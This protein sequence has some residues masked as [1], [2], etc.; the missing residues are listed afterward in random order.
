METIATTLVTP[1][2]STPPPSRVQ[3]RQVVQ[4]A[5]QLVALGAL[6]V[7]CFNVISPFVSLMMWA[8]ILAIALYPLYAGLKKKL[9]GRSGLAATLI[10]ILMIAVLIGPA[11]WM[12][13]QTGGEVKGLIS[14][15]RAGRITIPPPTEKIKI[16][17]LY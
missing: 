13:I 1:S 14:D 5:I 9:K 4:I 11:A 10:T 17:P 8:A 12:L 7:F 3:T 2:D 6:L 15:Y 16:W